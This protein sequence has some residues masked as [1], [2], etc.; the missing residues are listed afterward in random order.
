M[1]GALYCMDVLEKAPPLLVYR[2]TF[3]GKLLSVKGFAFLEVGWKPSKTF[4]SILI[5]VLELFSITYLS[6]SCYTQY[7]PYLVYMTCWLFWTWPHVVLQLAFSLF[8]QSQ[9]NFARAVCTCCP[10]L[11]SPPAHQSAH[12][13]WLSYSPCC[14]GLHVSISKAHLWFFFQL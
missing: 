11:L 1:S 9:P 7:V 8:C 14:R 5:H 4:Q 13:T 6:F 10:H 3:K 12:P 2:L